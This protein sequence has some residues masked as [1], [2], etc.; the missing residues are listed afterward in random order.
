MNDLLERHCPQCGKVM[1][2]QPGWS[3][4]WICPDYKKP[5]N[6]APPFKFKCTGAELTE[7]GADAFDAEC[8]RYISKNN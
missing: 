1:E 5:L 3:G 6:S 8:L 4:L 7:E 2:E